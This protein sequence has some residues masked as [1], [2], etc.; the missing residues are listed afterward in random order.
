MTPQERQLVDDLFER[1]A[2][3]EQRSRDPDAERVI[4]AGLRSAPNAV[5]AL[6]QTVLV[7]DEALRKA[8]DRIQELESGETGQSQQ[9]GGFLDN[10]RDAIFGGG[11]RPRGA[12]PQVRGDG[13]PMGVPPAFRTGNAQPGSAPYQQ[14]GSAPYQQQP[15]PSRGGSFLGTAAAAAAGVIGGSLL[16][17]SISGMMGGGAAKQAAGDFGGNQQTPW[18][19]DSSS[20]DLAKQAGLD[21]VGQSGKSETAG[22]S[23][24][25]GLHGG[26]DQ[27]YEGA[28]NADGD[29]FGLDLG[30]SD[31]E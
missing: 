5:Y 10:M 26:N 23:E 31:F 1:L 25:A 16:L 29:D 19:G 6:V 15:E 3:L 11:E 14:Q 20:S 28:D 13:Q 21:N 27:P 24:H 12:V 4:I 8:N 2:S 9:S 18:G 30:G 7:Q 17:N 22:N